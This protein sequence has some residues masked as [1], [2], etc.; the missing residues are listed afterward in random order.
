MCCVALRLESRSYN[1]LCISAYPADLR[2]A[3]ESYVP[4][5]FME[6]L[7]ESHHETFRTKHAAMR[8]QIGDNLA[9]RNDCCLDVPGRVG[10]G[11]RPGFAF[12]VD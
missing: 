11:W 8:F 2:P 10:S 1:P 3:M 9:F 5:F 4:Q 6:T 12:A 7:K